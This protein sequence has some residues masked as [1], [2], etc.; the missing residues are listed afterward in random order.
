VFFLRKLFGIIE[1]KQLYLCHHYANK[2]IMKYLNLDSQFEPFEQSI[3]FT[4]FVFNGGE[5]HIKIESDLTAIEEITITT[6]IKS[7]NDIG[8][9]LLAVDALRR[10]QVKTINLFLPYFPGARQDRVMVE[11]ES[12]TVKVYA[13]LINE[14]KLNSVTVFDPHSE[15]TPALLENV[16][17]IANNSF[18]KHATKGLK[19]FCLVAP[20]GGA[21]KKIYKTAQYLGG[22]PV[23]ECGKTR[24]VSTGKLSGFKVYDDN[25]NGKTC[26]VTDDICDGGGTFLGLAT[27]L[28]ERNAGKLILVVSHG[29]FSKGSGELAK[30]YD[31]IICTDSFSTL[32]DNAIK[33][34]ALKNV[35]E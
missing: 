28:K 5:P 17:V 7:F 29:I 35:L 13:N 21:L 31:A 24:D 25:L 4:A 34:I 18:V 32:D 27:A 9:L 30:V 3:A 12:L 6:R 15:V 14:L 8:L 33:Q 23:V 1:L 19:N 26:V 10:M 2:E 16:E 22:V 11:G 20:D